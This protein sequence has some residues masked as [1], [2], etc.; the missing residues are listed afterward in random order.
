MLVHRPHYENML[1]KYLRSPEVK[2]IKGVRRC[3]K[4][5][6]LSM[7]ASSLE[8]RGVP[9]QN[10]FYRR[11]DQFGV[12]LNPT[13]EWL[14]SELMKAM[15]AAKLTSNARSTSAADASTFYVLLDEIQDV[16]DWEKVVRRLH[17]APNVDVFI[18]GS[19]AHILSS[20]LST[21]LG[22][23]FVE[24]DI[25][26]LSFEEY[27]S[28][29]HAVG[30]ADESED[31]L[32]ARYLTYGGMPGIFDLPEWSANEITR[33]LQ[34]VYE[35]VIL[36]DVAL[37]ERIND[38]DL[39]SKLVRYTFMTSG[40]PF[41]TKSIV[42][43]LKSSGR[44]TSSE[45]VDNYLKALINALILHE[46]EQ[47]GLSGRQVLRPLRKFYPVDTGLRNLMTGFSP[48]DFGAQLECIVYNELLRRGYNVTVG[49]LPHE[50]EVDFV[51]R[52]GA[53]RIYIQ[54]TESL[55]DEKTF[56]RELR[57][58]A[59]IADSF[60]K[61]VLTLGPYRLGTTETGIR[62]INLIDWICK[63]DGVLL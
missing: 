46:C 29:S 41:S 42:N 53:E 22:G 30:K 52:K 58:Y 51:A 11:M 24:L 25:Y 57:P 14:E 55:E 48:R 10:I 59:S 19:N 40:S 36:N 47:T 61:L 45:T 5:T 16:K 62:V 35:T 38:L 43:T 26:P 23:R 39:L 2:V 34:T 32:F 31:R 1:A 3:G 49:S 18:T 33:M 8:E 7:L 12:P 50:E 17:T 15:D 28:F 9:K 6:L 56:T 21:L 27:R 4:S 60:P 63:R 54:V 20:D 37:H 44:R 13:A